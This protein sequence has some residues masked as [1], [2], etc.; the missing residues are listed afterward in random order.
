MSG[1]SFLYTVF[2]A[3]F[4]LGLLFCIGVAVRIFWEMKLLAAIF[5][6]IIGFGLLVSWFLGNHVVLPPM[7][8]SALI[9]GV[10]AMPIGYMSGDILKDYLS[11]R[12]EKV[13]ASGALD[14]RLRKQAKA[15]KAKQ[16]ERFEG[17]DRASYSQWRSSSHK[18][19]KRGA[20]G[21][22]GQS[23]AASSSGPTKEK[24]LKLLKLDASTVDAK[25][26]KLAY[27]K[28]ARQYHP[29][30][31]ASQNLTEAEINKATKQMQAINEA[32]DWLQDNGYA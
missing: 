32:Y 21:N 31:L 12:V 9:Y 25:A 18:E 13:F 14:E 16:R 6:G 19:E 29:D 22:Q 8:S 17:F 26:I 3:I 30:I 7:L 15:Y 20:A 5:I 11:I 28:L 1:L 23:N 4:F 2:E 27:R 24:M 10:I